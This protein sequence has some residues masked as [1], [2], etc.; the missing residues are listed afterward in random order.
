MMIDGS[1]TAGQCNEYAQYPAG[2]ALLWVHLF[3]FTVINHMPLVSWSILFP[4]IRF[5]IHGIKKLV[6]L[7]WCG[8]SLFRPH[9]KRCIK[10]KFYTIT[11]FYSDDCP[12]TPATFPVTFIFRFFGRWIL[13]Y[14]AVF[15]E[16]TVQTS[17]WR[18][19]CLMLNSHKGFCHKLT[20]KHPL[21]HFQHKPS[22]SKEDSQKVSG[23]RAVYTLR[24]FI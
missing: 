7:Y 20:P 10:H 2:R 11:N 19:S 18:A 9:S 24:Q 4:F 23:L 21:I 14:W 12:F 17:L 22:H 6:L 3:Y 13:V 16:M 1:A 8:R 5:V 15:W